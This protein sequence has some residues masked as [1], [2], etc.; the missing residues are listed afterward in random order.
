MQGIFVKKL[1]LYNFLYF[2]KF[3]EFQLKF[4]RTAFSVSRGTEKN[5]FF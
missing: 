1:L 4:L 2:E 3:S 5:Y